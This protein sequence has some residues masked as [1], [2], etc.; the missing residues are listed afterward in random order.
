MKASS[1]LTTVSSFTKVIKRDRA[2]VPFDAEKIVRAITKAG[3]ATKE[4][5][6]EQAIALSEK[7]ISHLNSTIDGATVQIEQIQD[8]VEHVLMVSRFKATAK[9]YI[10]FRGSTIIFSQK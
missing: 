3:L 1:P 2:H 9:A 10:L 5:N 7:V 8:A 4:Y 6:E